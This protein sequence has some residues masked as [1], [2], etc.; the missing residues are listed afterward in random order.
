M[1]QPILLT[2][3][4]AVISVMPNDKFLHE[5]FNEDTLGLDKIRKLVPIKIIIS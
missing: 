4:N 1:R 5:K 2:T 3:H